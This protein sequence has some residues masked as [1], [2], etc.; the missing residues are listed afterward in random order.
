M[1]RGGLRA[2]TRGRGLSYIS[3][4]RVDTL[5]DEMRIRHSDDILFYVHVYRCQRLDIRRSSVVGRR[6]TGHRPNYTDPHSRRAT[7][8]Q[9][10]FF[11]KEKEKKTSTDNETPF[12]V[13][14]PR[15]T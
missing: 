15:Q 4:T 11:L 13:R 10:D 2:R 12:Y 8:T 6:S 1:E 5:M 14:Q 9:K 7:H 3:Y